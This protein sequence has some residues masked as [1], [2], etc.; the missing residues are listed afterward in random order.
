MTLD[1]EGQLPFSNIRMSETFYSNL[2][3]HL[4]RFVQALQLLRLATELE[5]QAAHL[6]FEGLQHMTV[7]V[8]GVDCRELF[9]L[10]VAFFGQGTAFAEDPFAFL[11]DTP[12]IRPPLDLTDIDDTDEDQ[13][14]GGDAC[15]QTLAI[16]STSTTRTLVTSSEQKESKVKS[17]PKVQYQDKIDDIAAT[18]GFL[19]VN[20]LTLHNTRIP[21]SCHVKRSGSSSKGRSLYV[22]SYVDECSSPPYVSDLPS[23]ASHVRK[24]HLGHCIACPYCGARYYN[25]NGWCDHMGAKHVGLPWYRTQVNPLI[26]VCPAFPPDPAT[27]ETVISVPP[28]TIVE[29]STDETVSEPKGKDKEETNKDPPTRVQVSG[30]DR[31]S[32]EDMRW[33]M[34]FPPSDL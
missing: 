12:K 4:F 10:L 22:C 2:I 23:T 6:R 1:S 28:S 14:G 5:T 25:A 20:P 9:T 17:K 13:G 15:S 34:H 8:A 18:K 29:P 30:I 21:L 26:P 3:S 33:F 19:P 7:A 16:A 11:D 32:I 24:H 31:F 27:G